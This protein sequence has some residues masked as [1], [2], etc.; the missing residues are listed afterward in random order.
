MIVR[1]VAE[2]A[3]AAK[4]VESWGYPRAVLEAVDQETRWFVFFEASDPEPRAFLWYTD[5]P[6]GPESLSVHFWARPDHFAELGTPLH[7][8][9]LEVIGQLLGADRLHAVYPGDPR[10]PES[11]LRRYLRRRGWTRDAWGMCRELA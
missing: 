8:H 10:V 6:T 1:Q 2:P 3:E 5:G 7:M 11:A 9:A 4:L